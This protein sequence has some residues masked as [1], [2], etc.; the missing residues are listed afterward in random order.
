MIR[1][2]MSECS[3]ILRTTAYDCFDIRGHVSPGF[4]VVREAFAQN[5]VR[6]HRSDRKRY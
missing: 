1:K 4:E 5:F 3:A 2:G 6:R